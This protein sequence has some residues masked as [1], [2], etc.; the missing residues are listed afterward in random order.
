MLVYRM[1]EENRISA[2]EILITALLQL[3]AARLGT[4]SVSLEIAADAR[5]WRVPESELDLAG[6]CGQF[7][8]YFP[9]WLNPAGVRNPDAAL[10]AVK[11]QLRGVP[12][13][14]L[15]YGRL[16][17]RPG[18]QGAA[19]DRRLAPATPVLYQSMVSSS[20]KTGLAL[21]RL[22]SA[23]LPESESVGGAALEL[24]PYLEDRQLVLTWVNRGSRIAAELEQF[25]ADY[26][27]TLRLL[28][29]LC[30]SAGKARFTP[31]HF[32]VAGL[33]QK[34]LDELLTG[35]DN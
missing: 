15:G 31:S 5:N 2:D 25:A 33:S 12:A 14:G 4:S 10:K 21:R 22:W 16:L 11:E 29:T 18:S 9:V 24:R 35:L 32:P 19:E 1:P 3:L 23:P 28:L 7:I 13:S 8:S 17:Y 27:Q 26:L 30:S 6:T 34:E 20:A